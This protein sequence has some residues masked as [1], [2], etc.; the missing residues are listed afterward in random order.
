MGRFCGSERVV[1]PDGQVP[2]A[3]RCVSVTSEMVLCT[4]KGSLLAL[5]HRN[6]IIIIHSHL[7]GRLLRARTSH[8]PANSLQG[9]SLK[10]YIIPGWQL[11]V[12]GTFRLVYL[13]V[14]MEETGA[15]RLSLLVRIPQKHFHPCVL[16]YKAHV[17][18]CSTV[19][20]TDSS[21]TMWWWCSDSA[22]CLNHV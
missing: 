16:T 4:H 7:E 10:W 20:S 17:T 5:L 12:R 2:L 9:L 19:N 3:L 14:I 8:F 1:F 22:L 6:M 11:T 13:C 15:G 21:V 18:F